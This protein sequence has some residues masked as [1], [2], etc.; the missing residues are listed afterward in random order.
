MS[1]GSFPSGT[2]GNFGAV[3]SS[4]TS[5]SFTPTANCRIL[6][7]AGTYRAGGAVTGTPTASRSTGSISAVGA[8]YAT[9]DHSNPD[10]YVKVFLSSSTGSSPASQSLTVGNSGTVTGCNGTYA[11]IYDD[12]ITGNVVQYKGG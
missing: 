12:E 10:L 3:A 4:T 1:G 6:L 11:F 9:V 2:P 8:E 5:A 7:G